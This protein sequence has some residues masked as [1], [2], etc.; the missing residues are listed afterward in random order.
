MTVIIDRVVCIGCGV[1]VAIC[2]DLF[3]M[4]AENIAVVIKNPVPA[5]LNSA[6]KEAAESCTVEA[7]HIEE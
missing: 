1:C 6:A 4:D 5:D 2:P 3:E 7:I